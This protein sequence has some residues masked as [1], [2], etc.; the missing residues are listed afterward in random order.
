[1]PR[2]WQDSD[3]VRLSE[4]LQRH[5]IDVSPVLVSR[6]VSTVARDTRVHPVREYFNTLTWDGVLRLE[7]WTTAYLGAAD[8]PLNRAFGSLWMISA[9]ARVLRPGCKAD[10]MLILE[11]PQG[12]RKSAALKVLGGGRHSPTCNRHRT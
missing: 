1:V 6:C 5:E 12:A 9:V 7:T 10:H 2:A 4:W 3:D 11:G 8:T